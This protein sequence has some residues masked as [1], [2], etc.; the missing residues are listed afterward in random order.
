VKYL[1]VI[2]ANEEIETGQ[3]KGKL[4]L[5]AVSWMQT[6]KKVGSLIKTDMVNL[7]LPMTSPS[8]PLEVA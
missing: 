2:E 5:I 3:N 7:P 6:L 8:H 4:I 1:S